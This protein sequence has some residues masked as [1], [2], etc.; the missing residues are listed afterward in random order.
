MGYV[1]WLRASNNL[2]VTCLK[3]GKAVGPGLCPPLRVGQQ[4]G[5]TPPGSAG[6]RG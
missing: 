1:T 3:V 5:G 6:S 2:P 4:E